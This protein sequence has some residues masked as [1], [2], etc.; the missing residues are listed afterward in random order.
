MNYKIN[1]NK[2]D[3]G[4]YLR[5]FASVEFENSF[6]VKNIAINEGSN[7]LYVQFPQYKTSQVDEDGKAVYKSVAHPI[8]SEFAK[9]LNENILKTYESGE[10][11][12]QIGDADSNNLDFSISN[13]L[14]DNGNIKAYT[15]IYIGED[16]VVKNISIIEGS[17]GLFVSNPSSKSKKLDD[18]GKPIYND[19]AF[20]TT[21]DS[22][23]AIYDAIL[24]DYKKQTT[25]KEVE[26][27]KT[28]TI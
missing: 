13:N 21:A 8:T 12:M 23:K 24:D 19:I 9:E 11:T 14:V 26:V 4:T 25:T 3:N 17:K 20:P 18:N 5:G 28:K 2:V 16:F 22:R 1:V 6:A 27:A 10:K 15:N 7:G